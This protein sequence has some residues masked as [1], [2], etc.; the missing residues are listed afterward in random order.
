MGLE[1][2]EL[3]GLDILYHSVFRQPDTD[4]STGWKMLEDVRDSR[5]LLL[6]ISQGDLE[7]TNGQFKI[8]L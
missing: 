7:I 3:K 1:I 2:W 5:K 6:M 4:T 8:N